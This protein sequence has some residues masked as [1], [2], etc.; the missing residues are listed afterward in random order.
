LNLLLLGL[1]ITPTIADGTSEKPIV[2]CTTNVLGSLVEEFMGDEAEIVV[3]VRPGLC[4]ADYDIK[5]SDIYAVS[6]AKILFYHDIPGEKPWLQNLINAAGNENLTLVK[7][8]GA[9][10]TPEGAKQCINMVGGNLSKALTI[11]LT[12]KILAMLADVDTAASEIRSEAQ[13]LDVGT[14]KVIC[15]KWQRT[16]IEWVGF[17]V[18]ADYNPPETLSAADITALVETARREGAVLIVDN[19]QISVEFGA[20]IASEVG[21]V[22]VVLTNFPGAIP[23]TGNLT[24]MFRYNAEHLFDGLRTWKSTKA[25]RAEM[26]NL[27]N[28]LTTF[29]AT[30]SVAVIVAVVEAVWLYI[31]RKSVKSLETRKVL[32]DKKPR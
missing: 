29:Q 13:A 5:P 24:Q 31:G 3:L 16:F 9:Y 8:P 32:Q 30:T 25:L 1:Y 2:V 22:H 23:G 17:Q 19:L 14:V 26:E 27:K 12:A 20:G 11:N 10:N 7:V 6:K 15:M 28:Q 21:A 4:P 18:V